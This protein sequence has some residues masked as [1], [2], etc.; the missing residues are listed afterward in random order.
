M[1]TKG[2]VF[3]CC[4]RLPQIIPDFPWYEWS[5]LP[6]FD[7]VT[8]T[9]SVVLGAL[10]IYLLCFSLFLFLTIAFYYFPR[11]ADVLKRVSLEFYH[12]P[13]VDVGFGVSHLIPSAD[14]RIRNSAP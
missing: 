14:A 1:G 5:G 4:C 6:A 2:Y 12:C 8:G 13:E 3:C 9:F 10:F 11:A 7:L